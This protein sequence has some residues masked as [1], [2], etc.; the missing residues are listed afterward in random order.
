MVG[1]GLPQRIR[2]E[3][4]QATTLLVLGMP[5]GFEASMDWGSPFLRPALAREITAAFTMFWSRGEADNSVAVRFRGQ[6]FVSW[7]LCCSSFDV[8]GGQKPSLCA[9]P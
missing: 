6:P 1:E 3:Q 4:A 7:F 5:K 2:C 9:T 8:T